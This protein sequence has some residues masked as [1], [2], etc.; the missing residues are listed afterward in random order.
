MTI[1]EVTTSITPLE[2]DIDIFSRTRN[3]KTTALESR[4]KSLNLK[5]CVSVCY[6]VPCL[7]LWTPLVKCVSLLT[8]IQQKAHVLKTVL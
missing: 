3:T 1:P 5:T 6:I 7:A 4:K 8:D 2:T